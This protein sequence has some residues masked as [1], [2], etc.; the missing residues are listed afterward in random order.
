MDIVTS[1]VSTNSQR[2][3]RLLM[4]P[5][6]QGDRGMMDAWVNLTSVYNEVCKLRPGRRREGRSR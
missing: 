3:G 2:Y 5:E 6:A 1:G 4:A